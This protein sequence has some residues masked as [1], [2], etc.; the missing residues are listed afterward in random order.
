MGN[1]GFIAIGLAKGI[2]GLTR[3]VA[4]GFQIL[5]MYLASLKVPKKKKAISVYLMSQSY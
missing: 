3:V 5:N 4:K 1:G 2:Q